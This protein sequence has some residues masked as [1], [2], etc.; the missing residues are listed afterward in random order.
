MLLNDNEYS[1]QTI[2]EKTNITIENLE[3]LSQKDWSHFKKPQVNGLISVIER[4]FDVDLSDLKAEANAYFKE[5]LE[6]EPD[7]PIDLVDAVTIGGSGNRIL[8]NFITILSLCA[9]GYAG[10]YYYDSNKSQIQ[11]EN[12]N[13]QINNNSG[14][15]KD[16]I[17]SAKKL[18]GDSKDNNGTKNISVAGK[19]DEQIKESK[20]KVIVQNS[21]KT[22][23][24]LQE[25]N[26]SNNVKKKFDITTIEKSVQDNKEVSKDTSNISTTENE[27][28][29]RDGNIVNSDSSDTNSN[30]KNSSVKG[31]V[32]KLLK[33]LDTNNSEAKQDSAEYN[34]TSSSDT[35]ENLELNS[36]D[37]NSS[38]SVANITKA[39]INL[40]S[41]RLWLGIY[42][43]TTHKRVSKVIRKPFALNIGEDKFAVVT[44]HNGFEIA[45]DS[46]TKKFTKK[47][48]VYFT[49]DKDGIKQLD[50]REYRKLTK[51]RAW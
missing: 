3:K 7:C 8:S 6:K 37:N 48:K 27:V 46:G 14:M 32:D 23:V 45:T 33:E 22:S 51:R 10:W 44:G 34:D 50:R 4:E 29:K 16:T 5:H 19:K 39:T 43:L 42:D 38:E 1:L 17:D 9:V 35:I 13:T 26:S 24:H 31:E 20:E 21:T 25:N 12:N 18:L 15:F 36:T 30:D 41:K 40:K 49:I 2:Q 28:Q 11:T 47:G